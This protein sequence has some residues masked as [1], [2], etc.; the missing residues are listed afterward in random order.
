M[1][2]DNARDLL[3]PNA[4]LEYAASGDIENIQKI[5]AAQSVDPDQVRNPEGFTPLHIAAQSGQF[6]V[7]SYLLS[8]S[9]SPNL[10]ATRGQTPLQLA[11][12]KGDLSTVRTLLSKNA[13]PNLPG[14]DGMT[15][16]YAAALS[17]KPEVVSCLLKGGADPLIKANTTLNAV[18]IATKRGHS[19]VLHAF[20]DFFGTSKAKDARPLPDRTSLADLQKNIAKSLSGLLGFD[21]FVKNFAI[22]LFDF[23]QGSESRIRLFWGDTGTGKSELGMRLAGLREGFPRLAFDDTG[24]FYFSAA[25]DGMD[26]G[27]VTEKIAP[28]SLVYLDDADKLFDSNSGLK[29][30][31]SIVQLQQSL[32]TSIIKKSVYWVLAGTFD[33]GRTGEDLS[34]QRLETLLGKSLAYKVDY[35]DWRLPGWTLENLLRAVRQISTRRGLTYEDEALLLIAEYC[36]SHGAVIGFDRID[37]TLYRRHGGQKGTVKVDEVKQLISTLTLGSTPSRS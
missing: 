13:D 23:L 30:A 21:F 27:A 25:D 31:K 26:F 5:F 15:P 2:A 17:N 10:K 18:D 36:L 8:K 33:S 35:V 3:A 6:I 12:M 34:A 19:D 4:L 20:Q 28:K 24:A 16:I 32:N 29:D 7:V 22:D 14:F 9:A 37:Q 1:P 11:A